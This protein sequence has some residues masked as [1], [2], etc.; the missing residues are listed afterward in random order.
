[1]IDAK[2]GQEGFERKII[3]KEGTQTQNQCIKPIIQ[4]SM[5]S[6]TCNI[7]YIGLSDIV[8][9]SLNRDIVRYHLH[10]SLTV[11]DGFDRTTQA[12]KGKTS[13]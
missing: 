9:N 6:F 10:R 11:D 5:L 7:L 13:D 12:I 1:M 3:F 2:K 8:Y 4:S